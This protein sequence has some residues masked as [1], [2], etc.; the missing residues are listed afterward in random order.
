MNED[1]I[2][3]HT[4]NF[5]QKCRGGGGGGGSF[6]CIFHEETKK[7]TVSSVPQM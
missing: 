1:V 5:Q 3:G 2:R 4:C 6:S 7:L